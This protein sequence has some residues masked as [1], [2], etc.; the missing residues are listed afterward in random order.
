VSVCRQGARSKCHILYYIGDKNGDTKT[1]KLYKRGDGD[2]LR[3]L[4]VFKKKISRIVRANV[5]NMQSPSTSDVPDKIELLNQLATMKAQAAEREAE[6]DR[7]KKEAEEIKM[8]RE[9]EREE[10]FQSMAAESDSMIEA[11]LEMNGTCKSSETQ[12]A[13]DTIK[14]MRDNPM[15]A[16]AAVNSVIRGM[17]SANSHHKKMA[18]DMGESRVLS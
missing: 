10:A 1:S 4:G 16:F 12:Q 14:K 17:V 6:M 18:D 13:M 7:M 2:P 3:P 15:D 8:I 9:R 5:Q 11:F